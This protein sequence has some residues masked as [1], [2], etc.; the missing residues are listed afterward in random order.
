MFGFRSLE[1]MATTFLLLLATGCS[2][3]AQNSAVHVSQLRHSSWHLQE[4][5]LP[6]MPNGIAQTKDGYIWMAAE[7]GLYRFDGQQFLEVLNNKRSILMIRA[8]V[9]TE[10]GSLWL[11]SGHKLFRWDGTAM[12]QVPTRGA[13]F[14]QIIQTGNGE[15]YGAATATHTS[16]CRLLPAAV[17][18][19]QQP[20][21]QYGIS[22]ADGGDGSLWV[23]DGKHIEHRVHGQVIPLSGDDNRRTEDITVLGG[24]GKG[25]VWAGTKR[26]GK[27]PSLQ[28]LDHGRWSEGPILPGTTPSTEIQVI[29]FDR[30]G[31][32]W[33]G[34]SNAGIYRI[35]GRQ[36]D[37][38][39]H[40]D[41]LTA[42]DVRDIFQDAEGSLWITTSAG[43]D[44]FHRSLV[45][46]W[47]TEEG[48]TADSVSAILADHAGR[49]WM[50]NEGSLDVL[51]NGHVRSYR[52]DNG[53][54]GRI[55]AG[56]AEDHLGRIW[57]GIDRHLFIF[58]GTTF[59]EVLGPDGKQLDQTV[60]MKE[61]SKSRMW[62][63]T[64]IGLYRFSDNGIEHIEGTQNLTIRAMEPDNAGGMW[65]GARGYRAIHVLA[66]AKT[67]EDSQ[68]KGP[69][70]GSF[71]AIFSVDGYQ[72][73]QTQE[74]LSIVRNG[75]TYNLNQANGIPFKTLIGAQLAGDGDLYLMT[76]SSYVKVSKSDLLKWIHDPHAILRP[77]VISTSNGALPGFATFAPITTLAPNGDLWF[78]TERF[79][80]RIDPKVLAQQH[81]PVPLVVE[82][83]SADGKALGANLRDALAPGTRDIDIEYAALS[84]VNPQAI[85]YKYRLEGFDRDWQEAGARRHAIYTNLPPGSYTFSVIASD[86]S[87]LW[88]TAATRLAFAISPHFYQT[89]WFRALIGL[90]GLCALWS[91]YL[92][93]IRYLIRQAN[94][95][96]FERISERERIAR[97]L[98]DSFFQGIQGLLLRFQNGTDA[99]RLDEP[100]R[101]M[102]EEILKQSDRVMLEGRELVLDLREHASDKQDL[103]EALADV[104]EELK[105]LFPVKYQILVQ[106][107]P[108]TVEPI[109]RQELFFIGRE[110]LING[111]QHSK[112][113][114]IEVELT[115][116]K[117][118]L[119]LRV[120]DNGKG[121]DAAIQESG[122][123]AGHFGLPGMRERAAKIKAQLNVWSQSGAGTEIDVQVP[124]AMAFA[125]KNK[126]WGWLLKLRDTQA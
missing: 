91:V 117:S 84:Y 122:Q 24:N 33:V 62:V 99:L 4:G 76:D 125:S 124:A 73:S 102:F 17:D 69:D 25:K 21:F 57:V 46:T 50:A 42:D 14:D 35:N 29:L 77:Q 126:Y 98:H 49:I 85:K 47:T 3:I 20:G 103:A 22:L 15:I 36:L 41:G 27:L 96:L 44:Q 65:L 89:R 108:E 37:R 31:A 120:R 92:V 66:H 56:L 51:E 74:G 88:S 55:V 59:K 39:G 75:T 71:S 60:V 72:F 19:P 90:A 6:G 11:A 110:A 26:G 10:D 30:E 53:L 40:V 87:G 61:D 8:M 43:L 28:I 63:R 115:F 64:T 16:V 32:V 113:A 38:F 119:I 80:Q 82:S 7:N 9:A 97:D 5:S 1:S 70:E 116:G 79:P 112:A 109:V 118:V 104:C 111:F 2:L 78:A 52:T 54:P 68:S 45:D 67:I 95:R 12:H 107:K 114:S 86:G 81:L 93:R 83:F 23:T 106:G 48:L 105:E 100:A 101:P 13:R 121:I 94:D 18:C 58:N 34:T 123:R